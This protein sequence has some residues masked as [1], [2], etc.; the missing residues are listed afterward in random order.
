MK[1]LELK[2]LKSLRAFNVYHTLM[3]G[4]K[5]LPMYQESF[6]EDFLAAAEAATEEEQEKLIRQ[7]IQFV[8]LDKEDLST[9]IS[10]TT[11]VNGIPIGPENAKNL[12][13]PDI[14]ERIVAVMLVISKMKIDFV[15]E[16]EK[17]KSQISQLT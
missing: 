15:S 17:K 12:T 11:D 10:F 3:L 4:L 5:M 14:Y 8:P 16:R 13:L 6:Y 1:V 2:D 9:T 7:A